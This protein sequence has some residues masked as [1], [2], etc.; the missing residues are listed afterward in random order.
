MRFAAGAPWVLHAI[1][2]ALQDA[3]TVGLDDVTTPL[4][5]CDLLVSSIVGNVV[6]PTNRSGEA[7]FTL[8][9][10]GGTAALGIRFAAQAFALDPL[11]IGGYVGS[12]GVLATIGR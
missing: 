10:P 3:F 9:L 2:G 12:N 4:P 5:G 8:Q 6:R 1:S 11:A 7:A